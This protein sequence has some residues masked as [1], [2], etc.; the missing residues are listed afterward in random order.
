M[1]EQ[2]MKSDLKRVMWRIVKISLLFVFLAL[3]FYL[4]ASWRIYVAGF[5][6]GTLISTYNVILTAR[7]TSRIAEQVLGEAKGFKTSGML[8]RF[9]TIA[10]GVMLVVR[11]PD[12]F[13]LIAFVTGLLLTHIIMVVDGLFHL[14]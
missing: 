3:P 4:I 8:I 10:I 2:I 14:Q 6:L 1:Q 5:I 11:F 9:A 7:R 13:D 12:I